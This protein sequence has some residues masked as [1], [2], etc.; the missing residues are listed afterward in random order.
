VTRHPDLQ[1]ARI[2]GS[3]GWRG[4]DP[5]QYLFANSAPL[6]RA[7]RKPFPTYAIPLKAGMSI[8][9]MLISPSW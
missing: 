8:A 3:Y 6:R 5:G 2:G 9:P 4:S 1:P 7:A